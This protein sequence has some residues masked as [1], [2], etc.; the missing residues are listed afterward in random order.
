MSLSETLEKN[1]SSFSPEPVEHTAN[2]SHLFSDYAEILAL[3]ANGDVVSRADLIKRFES[4]GL[5]VPAI[6]AEFAGPAFD[7]ELKAAEEDDAFDN[8]SLQ[9]YL[10]LEWRQSLLL[11]D[12]PFRVNDGSIQLLSDLSERQGLYIMLLL[13]SNL[14]YFRHLMPVLTADFEQVACESFRNYMPKSA[15]VRQLGKNSDFVG[16]AR[17]KII[18]LAHEMDVD[19]DGFEVQRVLGTQDGGL[20]I[21]A[22]IPF[23]DRYANLQIIFGQCACGEKW[24]LKQNET[25]RFDCSYLKIKKVDAMHALFVPRGLSR[26]HDLFEA[27]QITNSLLFDRARILQFITGTE[28]FTGLKSSEV[29]SFF[30]RLQEDIV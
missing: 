1:Y 15:I 12:Y 2:L 13:C 17:D 5:S 26:D 3:L 21:I 19:I 24:S 10:H 4:F 6:S 29:V 30:V 20:D 23:R 28:F 9:V 25:R 14:A 8:W 11:S 16:L 27:N 18:A 7:H 22:W